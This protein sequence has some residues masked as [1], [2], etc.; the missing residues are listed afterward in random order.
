MPTSTAQPSGV[1]LVGSIPLTTTEEVLSKVCSALPGRL[2]SIPD[3]ETSVRNNYIGWQ[4]DCFPK[5]TRDSILGVTTAEVPPDHRGTFSLESVKPTQYDAAALESY[6]TF[7]KLRNKGAIPQGVMF[8]VSL[9]SPLNSVKAH[10]KADFQP[11]LEPLYEHRILESLATIIEGIPAEDL[12]IQWDICL[13]ILVLEHER[14]DALSKA[15]FAPVLEGI[16]TRMQRLC[17]AV[18][19]GIPLGLH[20]CYGDYRHKHFVEPQDLSLVVRLVNHITKAVDR[21]I[22]WIHMPVPKDRD[23]SAY[24]EALSQLDVGDDVELYLG[25]VHANDT[26]GTRRRIRTAQSVVPRFGVATECGMG[27][28]PTDELNSILQISRDLTSPVV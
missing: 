3:G 13:E 7:I 27:R 21:P 26:E 25:L 28:T 20:L 2:R 14:P 15:H 16:V 6:K 24:F 5:K 4:L 9:P 8:Q 23:D 12:A 19:S 18:P 17:K 10:V 11:Q 22:S 1:L